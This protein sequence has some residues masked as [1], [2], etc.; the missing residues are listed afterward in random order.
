M[1]HLERAVMFDL[2]VGEEHLVHSCNEEI[3]AGST[4]HCKKEALESDVFTS[5]KKTKASSLV[6]AQDKNGDAH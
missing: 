2:I 1:I 5:K 3:F 6:P 4:D